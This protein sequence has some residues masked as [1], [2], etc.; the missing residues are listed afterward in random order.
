V[1]PWFYRIFIKLYENAPWLVERSIKRGLKP[2]SQV[3]AE[4]AAKKSTN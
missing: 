2:T 3:L 4:A 1:A